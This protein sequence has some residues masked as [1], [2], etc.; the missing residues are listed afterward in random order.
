M[1]PK[2]NTPE[3]QALK[4]QLAQQL[5]EYEG[6][7]SDEQSERLVDWCTRWCRH[8]EGCAAPASP[9]CERNPYS[10]EAPWFA[11]PTQEEDGFS[12]TRNPRYAWLHIS[13]M[14]EKDAPLQDWARDYLRSVM[15]SLLEVNHAS[16]S[17]NQGSHRKA[18][19]KALQI[20]DLRRLSQVATGKDGEGAP[21]A[22]HIR[23][24]ERLRASERLNYT[25]TLEKY[26]DA[27]VEDL[28]PISFEALERAWRDWRRKR[29][30]L[31]IDRLFDIEDGPEG[32]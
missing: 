2:P 11:H 6:A 31:H 24:L 8:A 23:E 5:D 15:K 9:D 28:G 14:L 16:F 21:H 19:C 10:W 29:G 30:P 22:G 27:S 7:P 18:L 32:K 13:E 4:S 17:G 20:D 25:A 1:R 12:E 26:Y 3:I